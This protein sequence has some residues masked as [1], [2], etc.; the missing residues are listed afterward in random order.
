MRPFDDSAGRA[1]PMAAN[2]LGAE[3]SSLACSNLLFAPGHSAQA[4]VLVIGLLAGDGGGRNALL[5]ACSVRARRRCAAMEPALRTGLPRSGRALPALLSPAAAIALVLRLIDGDGVHLNGAGIS[6][7]FERV[8]QLAGPLLALAGLEP[9]VAC[10]AMLPKGG[11]SHE[12]GEK[13][14]PSWGWPLSGHTRK[15]VKPR[16][17]H[18]QELHRQHHHRQAPRPNHATA[19]RPRRG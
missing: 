8:R 6:G 19:T 2:Q 17:L 10:T 12:N 15:G 1:P 9:L 7:L 4:P 18:T 11:V 3:A 5:P 16:T 14:S 13:K